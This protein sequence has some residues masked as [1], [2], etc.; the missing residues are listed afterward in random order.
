[1]E[2]YF[3]T[4]TFILVIALEDLVVCA[5]LLYVDLRRK[6]YPGFRNFVYCSIAGFL[7]FGLLATAGLTT[8]FLSSVL[9]YS[10]SVLSIGF[11]ARGLDRFMGIRKGDLLYYL[12]TAILAAILILVTKATS[13]ANAATFAAAAV[14]ALEYAYC[15][16]RVAVDLKRRLGF[17]NGVVI[18]FVAANAAWFAF[19]SVAAVNVTGPVH[20]ILRSTFVTRLSFLVI[21]LNNIGLMTGLIVLNAQR[22][23]SEL[24]AALEE[25]QT[26]RGII[27]ICSSCKKIR[28][29]KGYWQQVEHYFQEHS[30]AEFTHSICP[31]C[32]KKL[33]PD[34]Y[35]EIYEE[36]EGPVL[37]S[38]KS[39]SR[40]S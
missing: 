27:P 40:H 39:G 24:K 21:L 10:L 23:E 17:T 5:M 4:P 1:M 16:R 33:Y 18:L 11:T 30:Q 38:R 19:R 35:R 6:T 32:L 8:P 22:I 37:P 15:L 31:E 14:A 13:L 3:S 34:A 36:G 9:A 2:E 26:L 25:V 20:D 29:D 12:P 7:G 28:N